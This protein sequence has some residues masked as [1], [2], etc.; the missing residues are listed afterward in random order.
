MFQKFITIFN[1]ITSYVKNIS[2]LNTENYYSINDVF[3]SIEENLRL[4][5]NQFYH[6]Y[7][8]K[9]SN[10]ID[11]FETNIIFL[12]TNK[13][14]YFFNSIDIFFLCAEFTGLLLFISITTQLGLSRTV[15]T[16]NFKIL[17]QSNGISYYECIGILT[18]SLLLIIFDIFSATIE[19]DLIDAAFFIVLLLIIFSITFVLLSL[20]IFFYYSL[21]PVSGGEPFRRIIISD[22]MNFFLCLLRVFLCWTRYIFYDLQVELVDL[23]LQYTDDVNGLKLGS[24]FSFFLLGFL[25]SVQL[26]L[27]FVG[28][29]IMLSA[30]KFVIATF[31]LWL[32]LD[33]FIL[34]PLSRLTTNW[35]LL[36]KIN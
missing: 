2:T 17:A 6:E 15:V 5:N 3:K 4:S 10:I 16:T 33:L 8:H 26:D 21:T 1:D 9:Y 13:L 34:R 31:L 14:I 18:A 27:I 11:V 25:I 20:N 22:I 29:Q 35:L 36:K 30:F 7:S 32:I 12:P 23:S 19:E 28:I 24:N